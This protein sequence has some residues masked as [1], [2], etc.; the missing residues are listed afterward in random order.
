MKIYANAPH[1]GDIIFLS[2]E[3]KIDRFFGMIQKEIK[4]RKKILS[5][6]NGDYNNYLSTDKKMP[7]L[8]I[9]LNNYEAFEENYNIKYDDIFLS[10]TREGVKCGMFFVITASSVGGIRYRLT[11]NFS[12]KIA[13]QL[14]KEDD[15][16]IILE[17]VNKKRP[18]HIF[19]RGLTMLNNNVY[20]FQTA[21]ICENINY[22]T[23]IEETI[24]E[25]NKQN[26]PK[27]SKI[28]TLPNILKLQDIKDHL[29]DV[30]KVPLGMIKKNLNIYKYDFTKNF[31]NIILS[32]DLNNA[33]KFAN[34]ILQEIT[35]LENTKIKVLDADEVR[36][37]K[38]QTL[39]EK[40]N[41]FLSELE[42]NSD[43]SNNEFT[44][45]AIIGISKFI[46][47]E[48]FDD[49]KF[50][51]LLKKL[52][53]SEKYSFIIVENVNVLTEYSYDKWYKNNIK[54]NTCIWIG[55]GIE[56]QNLILTKYNKEIS[57]NH[58]ISYGYI[59]DEG[60]TTLI[61]LVGM[62]DSEE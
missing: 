25:L 4:T 38:V 35:Q 54:K 22:N 10:L 2:E 40:F 19:G 23:Q 53:D 7:L 62:R 39:E 5:D 8:M 26:Q 55:K 17:N 57:Y 52:K 29:K 3:E 34:I 49:S 48:S 16:G 27:A 41:N 12:K 43:K 51:K 18:S 56:S 42:T 60:E 58:N 33:V 24:K 11:Q 32:K 45:C 50:N 36:K 28:A 37:E 14:N 47:T 13:L 20:E 9:M 21:K 59:V 44:I 15:Y 6:Y 46:S 31:M 30:S 1:V 61:K